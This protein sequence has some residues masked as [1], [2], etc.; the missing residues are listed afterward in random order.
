MNA[1]KSR[2]FKLD[3]GEGHV[4][5][6]IGGDGGLTDPDSERHTGRV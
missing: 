3:L 4:F 5:R 1:A 6:K 2:Y